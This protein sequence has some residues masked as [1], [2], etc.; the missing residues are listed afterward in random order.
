LNFNLKKFIGTRFG[1]SD[2]LAAFKNQVI[3]QMFSVLGVSFSTTD[4]K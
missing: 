2:F 4:S 1:V 3:E